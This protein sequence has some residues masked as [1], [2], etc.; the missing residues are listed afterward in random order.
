M[1]HVMKKTSQHPLL[2]VIAGRVI[3]I[4]FFSAAS[5]H[6]VWSFWGLDH[7]ISLSLGFFTIASN[8]CILGAPVGSTSF[9]ESFVVE[10]L[11]EDLG[12]IS[13]PYVYKSSCGFCDAFMMFS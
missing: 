6:V 8:F 12:T 5:E 11:H 1:G 13:S 9:V 10:V 7:Y 2:Y 4:R 3:N